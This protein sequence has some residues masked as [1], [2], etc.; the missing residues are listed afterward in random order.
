MSG[1]KETGWRWKD[2]PSSALMNN[3]WSRSLM[4]ELTS[5]TYGEERERERERERDRKRER[6]RVEERE[7][8]ND[9][10]KCQLKD[11][12]HSSGLAER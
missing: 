1:V 4:D 12:S 6:E 8:F 2:E 10:L 7:R 11:C 3:I 9:S 5:T